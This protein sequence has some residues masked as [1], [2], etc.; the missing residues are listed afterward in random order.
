MLPYIVTRAESPV[1]IILSVPHCGTA[2][3]ED[4]RE[5]FDPTLVGAPDDT[6]WFVHQLYD[7]AP[8]LGITMIR[9]HYS[10]WVIDLNRP[11]D[12]TPLYTDGRI[13]TGLCPT[14]DFHG[15][16]IYLKNEPNTAE[17]ERRLELYYHPYHAQV[18]QLLDET[19]AKFGKVLLWD[20]HSIRR[21]VPTIHKERFPDLILGSADGRSAHE[22]LIEAAL[23]GLGSGPYDWS[24]NYPF[25]G[26]H[27]TRSFGKPS[28]HQHALQLE[29]SKELY[30]DDSETQF[31]QTR[32]QAMR[33]VLKRT[34]DGLIK[35]LDTLAL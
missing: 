35:T 24:Y 9:A 13:I 11:P 15:N 23:I 21:F 26:G 33:E 14:T 19:H 7:F 1:P 10:R 2:F 22:D 16:P 17:I 34:F 12:S 27:I 32:A 31:D 8:A 3:P 5:D 6:D 18:Q 25:K 30:M 4:I 29:M 28:L 20:A